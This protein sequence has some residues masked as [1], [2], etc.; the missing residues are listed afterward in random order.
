MQWAV[1]Q[2]ANKP[3]RRRHLL[4]RASSRDK[5]LINFSFLAIL[6]KFTLRSRH[7]FNSNNSLFHIVVNKTVKMFNQRSKWRVARTIIRSSTSQWMLMWV[8]DGRT[9]KKG[10]INLSSH[11]LMVKAKRESPLQSSTTNLTRN[12]RI[13]SRLITRLSTQ[14][15]RN[16]LVK[17]PSRASN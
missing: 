5:M 13:P 15:S 7:W 6:L 12:Q 16:N 3:T 17:T 4:S 8:V 9:R 1:F 11:K 2:L 14:C 10:S